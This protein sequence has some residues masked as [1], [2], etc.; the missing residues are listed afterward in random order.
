[1]FSCAA[2]RA[3]RS[4]S[5]T[6]VGDRSSVPRLS[7]GFE[8]RNRCQSR[9]VLNECIPWFPDVEL[10]GMLGFYE[11]PRTSVALGVGSS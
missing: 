6:V 9:A 2:Y 4:V 8:V 5:L 10:T 1:M 3:R 11:P 7:A